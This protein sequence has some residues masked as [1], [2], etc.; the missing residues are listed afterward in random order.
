[1]Q[2]TV[3]MT[4]KGKNPGNG[5]VDRIVMNLKKKLTLGGFLTL[6]CGYIHVYDFYSQTNLLLYISDH[7]SSGFGFYDTKD[8]KC[9][10]SG[11]DAL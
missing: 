2:K 7:W 3:K 11:V 1:M 5:H 9:V 8:H 4:L 10:L 6:S